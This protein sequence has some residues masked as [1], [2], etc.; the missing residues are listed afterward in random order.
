MAEP[1]LTSD[2]RKALEHVRKLCDRL[3]KQRGQIT[4]EFAATA[5]VATAATVEPQ[6]KKMLRLG[7]SLKK[8]PS[9]AAGGGRAQG[10]RN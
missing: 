9:T 2:D 3:E 10:G 5:L 6:I 7:E 4:N 1:L 8:Q